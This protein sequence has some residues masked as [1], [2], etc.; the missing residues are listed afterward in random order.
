V[1]VPALRVSQAPSRQMRCVRTCASAPWLHI[2]F[3]QM[4][5]SRQFRS[6]PQLWS[7]STSKP[8][9][10]LEN[11]TIHPFGK[12]NLSDAIFRDVSWTVNPGE[13]WV[14][15][16][17][18]NAN[19]GEVFQVFKCKPHVYDIIEPLIGITRE[20]KNKTGSLRW[21]LPFSPSTC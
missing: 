14:I 16:S 20:T 19:R 9:I 11:A 1:F 3:I 8:I 10:R 13:A 18:S 4:P 21:C 7:D 2:D 17:G 6:F 12:V 15:I 5:K